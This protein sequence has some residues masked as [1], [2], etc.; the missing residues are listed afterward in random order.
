M[1]PIL[2]ILSTGTDRTAQAATDDSWEIPGELAGTA[3]GPP[4]GAYWEPA[5]HDDSADA[6]SAAIPAPAALPLAALR[7]SSRAAK[8]SPTEADMKGW[9]CIRD[10][11]EWPGFKECHLDLQPDDG[12][13]E[14]AAIDPGDFAND[15][16]AWSVD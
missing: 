7:V 6:A 8:A 1:N 14:L 5:H 15:M 10:A 12:L 13:G 3:R 11:F 4:L 2:G 16:Q 9:T